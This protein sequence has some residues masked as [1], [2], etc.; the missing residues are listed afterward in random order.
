MEEQLRQEVRNKVKEL[1]EMTAK[2]AERAIAKEN[3]V[4]A[5]IAAKRQ[6]AQAEKELAKKTKREK[7]LP[8]HL[9]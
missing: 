2:A 9:L 6:K 8:F 4:R 5:E 7:D 1:Q 3:K